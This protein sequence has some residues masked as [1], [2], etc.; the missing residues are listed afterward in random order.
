MPSA[1]RTTVLSLSA[2]LLGVGV[3]LVGNGLQGTLLSVRA[4]M[5]AFSSA[6]IG[7]A[8]AAYFAGFVAGSLYTG[9]LVERA[10]HIRTFS[11]LASI[12]SAVTL[13]HLL[14]IEPITWAVLR[15]LSGF[16]FAG[17]YV[18]IESWL[19][20]KTENEYRGRVFATYMVVNFLGL[21]LGQYLLASADPGNF[22]L[23]VVVSILISVALVPVAMMRAAA[24]AIPRARLMSPLRLYRISPLGTVGCVLYG[25][26][27]GSFWGL[28]PVYGGRVGLTVEGISYF[29]TATILGGFALQWPLGRLSDVIDRRRVIIGATLGGGVVAAVLPL[30]PLNTPYLL[31]GAC[32]AFGGL[33][34]PVYALCVA[35]ANDY[36]DAADRVAVSSM[37][38]L[39]YGAGAAIGPAAAGPLMTLVGPPSLY[40]FMATSFLAITAFAL[41]RITQREGISADVR[42]A[43]VPLAGTQGPTPGAIELS[44]IGEE[45]T[46]TSDEAAEPAPPSEPSAASEPAHAEAPDAPDAPADAASPT[47]PEKG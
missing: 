30:V 6:A 46:E 44:T 12:A 40:W 11:A 43:F 20:D 24:P 15:A 22:H 35:H 19:N 29:M 14:L 36:V 18:V 38:L 2:L 47:P 9:A 28:A 3:M 32:M 10:G 5:E 27:M 8:T 1:F 41:W 23:F 25:L 4:T 17:I 33:G 39:L 45:T 13:A 26:A 42:E 34:F 7:W 31:Y 16:C 37:L 21:T